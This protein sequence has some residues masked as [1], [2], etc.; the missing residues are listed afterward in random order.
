M[1]EAAT[2]AALAVSALSMLTFSLAALRYLPRI[3]RAVTLW[4]DMPAK[5]QANTDAI[6]ANTEV[7]AEMQQSLRYIRPSRNSHRAGR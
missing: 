3:A 4:A 5:V 2:I 1:S 6:A 7:I